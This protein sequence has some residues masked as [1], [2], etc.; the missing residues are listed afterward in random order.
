MGEVLPLDGLEPTAVLL[1]RT[2]PLGCPDG[3]MCV[4]VGLE[5]FW[6]RDKVL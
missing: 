4:P 5:D 6:K 3:H 1:L 2:L